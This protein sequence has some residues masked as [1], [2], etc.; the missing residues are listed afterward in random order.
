VISVRE[1]LA[2]V[3][4][5]ILRK[6]RTPV[7]QNSDVSEDHYAVPEE[8]QMYAEIGSGHD[9]GSSSITYAHIEPRELP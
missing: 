1:P 8:E 7:H 6:Q 9:S 3:R 4:E 5:K 2:R